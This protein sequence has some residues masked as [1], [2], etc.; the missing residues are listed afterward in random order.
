MNKNKFNQVYE[1]NTAA[2]GYEPAECLKKWKIAFPENATILDIGCGSG[3]NAN[4][5]EKNGFKVLGYDWS[6]EAI[7]KAQSEGNAT[8]RIKNI[9]T[10]SWG[11]GQYDI[12]I[13]FGCFHFF[14]PEL[15]SHYHEQLNN[16][17]KSAGIYINESARVDADIQINPNDNSQ[18]YAP[19]T[20]T[21]DVW[22]E[23]DYLNIKKLEENIL[24]PH[25]DFGQYPCWNVFARK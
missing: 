11:L 13:D 9:M 7:K 15:R 8:F 20:L 22:E 1:S 14:P 24:P 10:E 17:L 23:F 4:Y 12:V 21:K 18:N 3:R 16:V 19:P 5:L 25:G 2:W 6:E